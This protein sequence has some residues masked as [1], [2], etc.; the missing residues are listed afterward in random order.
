MDA[1]KPGS[2]GLSPVHL[3][4]INLLMGTLGGVSNGGALL[5]YFLGKAPGLEDKLFLIV[6]IVAIAL[7]IVVSSGL[8]LVRV[9]YRE[10]V[11]KYHAVVFAVAS[12]AFLC[13]ALFIIVYPPVPGSSSS[14]RFT[15]SVG[16]LTLFV[17]YTAYLCQRTLPAFFPQVANVRYLYLYVGASV[18]VVDIAT[19]LRLS[20]SLIGN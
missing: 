19:F 4:V 8:A 15:W 2:V 16:W 10:I 3:L 11:L 1:R 20:S 6:I 17:A 9:N 13:W 5:L 18:L 14:I 12:L 7:A